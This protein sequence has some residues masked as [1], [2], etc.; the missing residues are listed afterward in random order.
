[1]KLPDATPS[2]V[3]K[4]INLNECREKCLEN[5][6]C[7]VYTNLDIRG[8]GSGCAMWFGE[9]ID[10]RDFPDGG[11][12]LYIRMS[13]SEIGTRG[14]VFVTPLWELTKYTDQGAKGKPTTKIVVIVVPTA[15]LLA[16]LIL[17]NISEKTENNRETDQVQNM[18]LELPLFELAT[19]ANATDNFSINNKLGEGGF[20]PVYK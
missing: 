12:D 7:M 20:G 15:A 11:Q 3:S 9:L 8:G 5:S 1:M 16:A 13:A 17:S 14:L 19:I 10:M 2:R 6:S 4:S 18:D